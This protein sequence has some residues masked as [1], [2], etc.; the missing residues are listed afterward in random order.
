MA[1]SAMRRAA[2]DGT[3]C[4]MVGGQHAAV[5]ALS[6]HIQ[7]FLRHE[8]ER[9]PGWLYAFRRAGAGRTTVR[10][11]HQARDG[12]PLPIGDWHEPT[13][14]ADHFKLDSRRSPVDHVQRLRC[15]L[16]E[17]QHATGHVGPPV[18]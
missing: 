14:R 4:Q 2:R 16:R 6:S 17:V 7:R 13:V 8:V 9:H 3:V 18:R 12:S 1:S 15:G 10:T 5:S 11:E